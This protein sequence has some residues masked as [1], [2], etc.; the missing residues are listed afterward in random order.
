ML[1]TEGTKALLLCNDMLVR[2]IDRSYYRAH[3]APFPLALGLRGRRPL[4]AFNTEYFN[5][6]Y[7]NTE[8]ISLVLGTRCCS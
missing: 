4:L 3:L 5:T 1:E 8:T 6:E 2:E 7:F